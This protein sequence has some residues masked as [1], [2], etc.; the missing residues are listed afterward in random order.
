[1]E[2]H[3][4]AVDRR[5]G[6]VG[7]ARRGP[8]GERAGVANDDI[9]CERAALEPEL[10]ETRRALHRQPELAFAEH[11]TARLVADRLQAMGYEPRI[12]VGRT[13]VIAD[14]EGG[15]SGST[16]L[17]RADMDALPVSELPGRSYGS[18]ATGRM[19]ACGHD[20]HTS[21]LLGVAAS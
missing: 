18:Q 9:V 3:Q 7:I 12:G 15:M 16:L 21:A 2:F 1:M 20:A 19:H 5:D 4:R 13:G 17:I 10:I 11:Q 6:P 8:Q 14:L